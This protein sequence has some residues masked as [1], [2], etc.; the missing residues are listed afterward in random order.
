MPHLIVTN[1]SLSTFRAC[2]RLYQLKY[3]DGYRP[4]ENGEDLE[5]GTAM[6]HALESWWTDGDYDK[7]AARLSEDLTGL[8]L[9]KALTLIAGYHHRWLEDRALYEVIGLEV[10]FSFVMPGMKGVRAAGKIDGIVRRLSDGTTWIVEHK[11]TSSDLAPG[12]TYWQRL[13]MDSQI[14]MYFDGAKSLGHDVA[15]CL[16]DVI[17]KPKLRGR[18]NETPEQLGARVAEEIIAAPERYYQRSEIVRFEKEL[19][20]SRA[21][22]L[23]TTRLLR[24]GRAPRNVDACFKYGAAKP[25]S[26]AD[27]CAGNARIDDETKFRKTDDLHPELS[28]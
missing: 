25:C 14:S 24:T 5:L 27:V 8:Q 20:D 13:G 18:Q 23:L 17:G 4:V 11:T 19:D 9:G 22:V 10:P 1:S 15:G 21:D 16:Y 28:A 26:F 2:P 3:V 6:H 12:S 7:A